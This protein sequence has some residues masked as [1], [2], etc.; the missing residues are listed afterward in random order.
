MVS[1][2]VPAVE[3]R[4]FAFETPLFQAHNQRLNAL[5]YGEYMNILMIVD[6]LEFLAFRPIC[7][8]RDPCQ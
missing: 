7:F 5:P 2:A 6:M 8:V 4:L 3:A 1:Q